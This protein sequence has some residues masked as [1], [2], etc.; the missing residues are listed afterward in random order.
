MDRD[1]SL[2]EIKELLRST[3]GIFYH[4]DGELLYRRDGDG[5]HE[6][7]L[8]F[9][10]AYHLQN[11]LNE[12]S[13]FFVDCEFDSSYRLKQD[14]D[15]NP[16]LDENGEYQFDEIFKKYRMVGHN[17]EKPMFIDIIVH[18]RE[19]SLETD[20]FCIELKKWNSDNE[21]EREQDF[22]KLREMTL[23]YHYRYGFYL[24]LGREK[25]D[26]KWIIFQD[27]RSNPEEVVFE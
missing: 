6:R 9:R 15:G 2:D 7:C 19:K 10:L 3:L 23:G 11:K 8:H 1:S 18:K 14:A 20:F 27:G 16:I 22:K 24:I 26:C 21:K 25:Q 12:S 5:M 4:L 13:S 17:K